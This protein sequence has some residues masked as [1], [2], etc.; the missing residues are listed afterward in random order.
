MAAAA[1]IAIAALATASFAIDRRPATDAIEENPG[2]FVVSSYLI[3]AD[4]VGGFPGLNTNH[5]SAK[6]RKHERNAASDPHG[7]CP[8]SWCFS[9]FRTF[10]LS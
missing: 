9:W 1:T 2:V 5:E 10:V 3:I 8:F 6:R 7:V 4:R